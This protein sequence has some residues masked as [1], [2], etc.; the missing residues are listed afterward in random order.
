[1]KKPKTLETKLRAAIRLIWSRSRER[2]AIKKAA[3]FPDPELGKAF[4]CPRCGKKLH[5]KMGEV[6]HVTAVGPLENWRDIEGFIDRMF[7]SPQEYICVICH[8]TKTQIDR[9]AMRR[10]K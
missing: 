9:K 4:V 6:D 1:M 7:F 10:T 5:E 8:K 3:I 2:A